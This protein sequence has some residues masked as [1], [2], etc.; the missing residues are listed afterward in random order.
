MTSWHNLKFS[1]MRAEDVALHN[2][3]NDDSIKHVTFKNLL[4]IFNGAPLR[5]TS[6]GNFKS[7]FQNTQKDN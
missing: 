6:I 7:T 2:S 5:L 3:T 4:D 1:G